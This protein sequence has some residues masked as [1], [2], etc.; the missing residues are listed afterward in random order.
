[1]ATA[2]R[3]GS[4]RSVPRVSAARWTARFALAGIIGPVF[5]VVAITAMHFLRPNDIVLYGNTMS[6]YSVGP[7]GSISV[8]ASIALGLYALA[9]AFEPRR[10]VSSSPMTTRP[11][12]SPTFRITGWR[13]KGGHYV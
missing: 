7:Y 2:Q 9:L 6:F 13:I 10:A 3:G 11:F 4:L 1:M 8:A 5:F 12:G